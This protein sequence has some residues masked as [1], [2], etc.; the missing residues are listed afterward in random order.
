MRDAR[1]RVICCRARGRLKN[2]S[3]GLMVGDLVEIKL[4]KD[5]EG[6][7]EKVYPRKNSLARPPV[8]NL[9]QAVIIVSV[10]TPTLD[11]FLL[12]RIIISAEASFLE[13]VICL[14]KMD[15]SGAEDAAMVKEVERVYQSCGYPLVLASALTGQGIS[16]L[17]DLL[18]G[19]IS[20]L[21]GPS[22]VGKSTLINKIKPGLG[23]ASGPVSRKTGR[24]RHVTRHVELLSLEE[25][26]FVVDT[27][28]FHKLDLKGVIAKEFP[29]YFREFSSYMGRCRF[30]SCFHLAEPGCAVKEA[31]QKGEVA[32]W[33]YK[34]YGVFLDEL[35]KKEKH[36]KGG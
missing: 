19:K 3:G 13:I 2:E 14:N 16:R 12:D 18:K 10:S 27:P 33:R 21:A 23:L 36:F 30:H 31:V 5:E 26:I 17:K 22:G 24:G 29:F 6:V 35:R 32:S 34:H 28:G 15:L 25:D 9:D 1:G 4:V 20:V 7:I 8:A 11:L